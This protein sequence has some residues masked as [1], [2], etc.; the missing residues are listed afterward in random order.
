MHYQS[1]LCLA[2]GQ[3][4]TA[5]YVNQEGLR[6]VNEDMKRIT[7]QP[8]HNGTNRSKIVE[9]QGAVYSVMGSGLL[10]YY[11]ENGVDGESFYGAGQKDRPFDL[12]AELEEYAENENIFVADTIEELAEKIGVPAENLTDTVARYNADAENGTDSLLNK[13]PQYMIEL[14]DAPYYA[15]KLCSIIVNTNGGVRVD[16]DCRVVDQNFVPIQGLY[17]TGL[18]ISGFVTDVYETGN[19][20]CV[21]IWSGL[22]AGRSLVGQCLD[23]TVADDWF[24]PSEWDTSKD[25]P[26]FANQDEYEAYWAAK[27]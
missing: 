6:F 22:K 21:S 4:K 5:L 17:A 3:T 27:E 1:W 23:G 9:G 10:N 13:D 24:G 12:D 20:Q 2:A 7:G 18:T 11:K 25:L 19:C 26:I 8:T 15:F 16:H 14:G